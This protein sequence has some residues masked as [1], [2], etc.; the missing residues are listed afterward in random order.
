MIYIEQ[1]FEK[2]QDLALKN[3][4]NKNVSYELNKLNSEED[5]TEYTL[6]LKSSKGDIHLLSNYI[7]LKKDYKHSYLFLRN[8]A[9]EKESITINFKIH[10]PSNDSY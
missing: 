7:A 2:Y 6:A 1:L 3:D 8:Q 9:E 4:I 5:Y 10:H